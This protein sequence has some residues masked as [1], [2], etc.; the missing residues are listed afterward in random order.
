[1][2]RSSHNLDRLRVGFDAP[3]LV[4]NAGLV[5]PRPPWLSIR[6]CPPRSGSTSTSVAEIS[7]EVRSW[8]EA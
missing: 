2:K 5:L 1:M 6:A 8:L 7:R 3:G 4:S